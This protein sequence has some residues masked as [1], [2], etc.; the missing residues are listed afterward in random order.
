MARV[1]SST[2]APD[3]ITLNLVPKGMVGCPAPTA[4]PA[5]SPSSRPFVWP[6]S[7]KL[8]PVHGEVVDGHVRAHAL[9][10]PGEHQVLVGR[11]SFQDFDEARRG[12]VAVPGG[13]GRVLRLTDGGRSSAVRPENA[14][15]VLGV[16]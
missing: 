12:R 6:G 2:T 10:V 9:R 5:C 13:T 15:V 1:R 8:R 16:V 11:G 14:P 3:Y 4:R 7:G